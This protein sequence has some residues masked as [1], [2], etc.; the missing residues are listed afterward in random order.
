MSRIFSPRLYFALLI[1][2]GAAAFL[3]VQIN[4]LA[5]SMFP[6]E[7]KAPLMLTLLITT[8]ASAIVSILVSS[9]QSEQSEDDGRDARGVAAFVFINASASSVGLLSNL[10][11]SLEFLEPAGPN[12]LTWILEVFLREDQAPL[13]PYALVLSVTLIPVAWMLFE[14]AGL[15]ISRDRWTDQK[16]SF[17]YSFSFVLFL[18]WIAIGTK[19]K[20]VPFGEEAIAN[21]WTL[22]F[23]ILV[24]VASVWIYGRVLLQGIRAAPEFAYALGRGILQVLSNWRLWAVLT[25]GVL[26]VSVGFW[27]ASFAVAW[28]NH[29]FHLLLNLMG[30]LGGAAAQEMNRVVP[31]VG[32]LARGELLLLGPILFGF[33]LVAFFSAFAVELLSKMVSKLF[34]H[35]GFTWGEIKK[36]LV[37]WL[38][39]T[40][41]LI[42][43]PAFG[44]L[45]LLYFVLY[46][47]P[48]WQFASIALLL[49]ILSVDSNVSYQEPDPVNKPRIVVSSAPGVP[50]PVWS[51]VQVVQL[52]IEATVTKIQFC[53]DQ[54]G[55]FGWRFGSAETI[56]QS[57]DACYNDIEPVQGKSLI[58]LVAVST[59]GASRVVEESRSFSRAKE[60][61]IWAS[62]SFEGA[63]STYVLDLGMSRF[64]DLADVLR[65]LV[66]P[67]NSRRP[68][69]GFMAWSKDERATDDQLLK[70]AA[71]IIA[72]AGLNEN[73]SKCDLYEVRASSNRRLL[74]TSLNPCEAS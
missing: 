70:L 5:A 57:I 12:G 58:V 45:W 28:L 72:E 15:L 63:S 25:T 1:A 73:F 42:A 20:N 69:G 41:T 21:F 61:S 36:L 71:S 59:A 54:I 65:P 53:S 46:Q 10:L 9:T 38:L 19:W 37:S 56:E 23:Y 55:T 49:S 8:A 22:T 64:S 24:A 47:R 2:G 27:L 32:S 4:L 43:S 68:I 48:T 34:E 7:S 13:L 39:F 44:L 31:T 67:T 33:F 18:V 26:T 14:G 74:P 40:V 62:R 11:E 52:P 6:G 16:I 66:G 50:M 51:A 29:L 60:L 35:R 30:M 17:V 3:Y